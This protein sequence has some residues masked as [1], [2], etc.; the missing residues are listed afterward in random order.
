M[1]PRSNNPKPPAPPAPTSAATPEPPVAAPSPSSPLVGMELTCD[2]FHGAPAVA[3][4]QAVTDSFVALKV[5]VTNEEIT[6][7]IGQVNFEEGTFR[8]DVIATPTPPPPEPVAT[9]TP[10]PAPAPQ[11]KAAAPV[12]PPPAQAKVASTPQ[13]ADPLKAPS[14]WVLARKRGLG[15][16]GGAYYDFPTGKKLSQAVGVVTGWFPPEIVARFP[17]EFERVKG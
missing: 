10:R 3:I 5:E 2:D 16:Y 8:A 1:P 17:G 4:V 13:A 15:V 9:P 12:T 6:V 7:P 11:P 14:T